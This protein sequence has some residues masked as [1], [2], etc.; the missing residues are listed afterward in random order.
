M[1]GVEKKGTAVHTIDKYK[2]QCEMQ[3]FLESLGIPLT[4]V[5]APN[6]NQNRHGEIDNSSKTILIYATDEAEAWKTLAH[7]ALEYKLQQL[8]RTYRTII[9]ALIEALEKTAYNQKEEYLNFCLELM[10][11]LKQQLHFSSRSQND[12]SKFLN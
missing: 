2:T 1:A 3:Q 10:E 8:T 7:E 5:W 12:M 6:P 11:K 4:V 9:N